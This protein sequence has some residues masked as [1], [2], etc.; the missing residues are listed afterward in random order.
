[1]TEGELPIET[2]AAGD[3]AMT[4]VILDGELWLVPNAIVAVYE[5]VVPVVLELTYHDEGGDTGTLRV[6]PD[7]PLYDLE[8]DLYIH[9]ED[10]DP[11]T[12]LL[13]A[14][15]RL[16][17]I[18]RIERREGSFTVYNI[19]VENSH[20]Y[21][22]GP[23]AGVGAIL[24]HN[25]DCAEKV[26]RG[27]AG[28]VK[29]GQAGEAAVRAVAD[30]GP[31]DLIEVA[32]RKRFP[33]GLHTA[34]GVLTEVKNTR[35]QGYTRQLRDYAAYAIQNGMRFDLWVRPGAQL[36]KPLLDARKAGQVNI[37]EIPLQ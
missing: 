5:R 25:N 12:P 3:W 26:V 30:I 20:N 33:D 9:A 7:H 21:F 34:N 32:G 23:A 6:T 36:S 2:L 14:D 27:G 15:G 37:R 18:D 35:A 13:M 8:R 11:V 29:V 19:E 17:W 24:V 1:M 16:A 31:K 4:P 22:A 28:P 10:F